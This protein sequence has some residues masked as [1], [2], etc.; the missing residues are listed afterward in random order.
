MRPGGIVIVPTPPD[1]AYASPPPSPAVDLSAA[2]RGRRGRRRRP[3]ADHMP[4]PTAWRTPPAFGCWSP[5]PPSTTSSRRSPPSRS[6]KVVTPGRARAVAPPRPT[7]RLPPGPPRPR[8]TRAAASRAA[9]TTREDLLAPRP[10]GA[11]PILAGRSRDGGGKGWSGRSGAASR[12]KPADL[13]GDL[14]GR[15][16]RGGLPPADPAQRPR[17]TESGGH[18]DEPAV[19]RG[20]R[21]RGAVALP[22]RRCSARS[23]GPAPR[24]LDAARRAHRRRRPRLRPPRPRCLPPPGR[25][26]PAAAR[27]LAVPADPA[28]RPA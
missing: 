10:P 27:H 12:P 8:R 7:P 13:D 5:R 24:R 11:S 14:P 15:G 19:Q 22:P 9:P 20:G 4:P 1:Q 17:C 26:L 3:T 28:P 23:A 16:V 18:A 6:R 21:A 2:D 25:G